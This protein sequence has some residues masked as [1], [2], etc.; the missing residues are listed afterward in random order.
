L[1]P[2]KVTFT[3]LSDGSYS[4]NISKVGYTDQNISV[5]MMGAFITQNI[6]LSI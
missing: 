2:G 5:G 4:A 6:T 3:G 1:S